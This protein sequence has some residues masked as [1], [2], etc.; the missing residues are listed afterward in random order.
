MLQL[1]MGCVWAVF[2]LAFLL[3]TIADFRFFYLL[4][5]IGCGGISATSFLQYHW[6]REDR[7]W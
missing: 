6:T 2:S 7:I 4:M 5:A 3:L 1:V